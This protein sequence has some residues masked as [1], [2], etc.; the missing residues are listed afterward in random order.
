MSSLFL[1]Q[2]CSA[3]E[4]LI[5]FDSVHIAFAE[6]HSTAFV[7][8]FGH[9]F[10]C[11]PT[12]P[13]SSAADLLNSQAINFGAN[14][15][16]NGN[17]LWIGNYQVQPTHELLRRNTVYDNRTVV[18]IELTLS[19]SQRGQLFCDL[20]RRLDQDYRYDFVR[21]N[22]GHFMLDWLNGPSLEEPKWPYFTPR[23]AVSE[24]IKLYPPKRMR[25]FP[26]A[27]ALIEHYLGEKL[28]SRAKVE[29]ASETDLALRILLLRYRLG[30]SDR[31]AYSRTQAELLRIL[32][33][34]AGRNA[35]AQVSGLET[36]VFEPVAARWP[37][38]QEGP[39]LSVGTYFDSVSGIARALADI[40]LGYRDWHTEPISQSTIREVHF[41]K[42][43][44]ASN[45]E[46]NNA[47][48][49]IGELQTI[50]PTFSLVGT[51]SSGMR[52]EYVGLPNSF[53]DHGLCASL[54]GGASHR[55]GSTWLTAKLSGTIEEIQDEAQVKFK[56]SF[57]MHSLWEPIFSEIEIVH[58]P[59]QG[60]GLEAKLSFYSTSASS[61]SASLIMDP[62]DNWSAT[63]GY[64]IRF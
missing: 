27:T 51:P 46:N 19:P 5:P 64:Q 30:H 17:G 11:L 23:E 50:R 63:L 18:F 25:T 22:C 43:T 15:S 48:L 24:A 39:S 56:P 45:G 28:P 20:Q 34:P 6:E 26:S 38:E 10:I 37:N 47:N 4:Q 16:S 8:G 14:T 2:L 13:I 21:H 29:T 58:S 3:Q 62:R 54:W 7:S 53:G 41:L 31:A 49:V 55:V 1:A 40:S 60:M 44:I 61:L 52:L 33:S 12:G 35:A 59:S 57:T 9:V 32:E 42:A 36:H